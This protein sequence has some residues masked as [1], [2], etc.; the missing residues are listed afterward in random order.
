M[1][2]IQIT[3]LDP[4]PFV[5][6]CYNVSIKKRLSIL[7]MFSDLYAFVR[8]INTTLTLDN[9]AAKRSVQITATPCTKLPR[10]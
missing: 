5:A 7:I 10:G 6:A 1:E 8:F 3:L 2:G 4:S 9:D